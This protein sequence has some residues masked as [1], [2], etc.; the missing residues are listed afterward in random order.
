MPFEYCYPLLLWVMLL[1][2]G[3]NKHKWTTQDGLKIQYSCIDYAFF[4][5]VLF[6]K[7]QGCRLAK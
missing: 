3:L 1:W 5:M 4:R 2:N 6:S 7:T